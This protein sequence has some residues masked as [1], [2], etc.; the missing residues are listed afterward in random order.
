M[1]KCRELLATA[2]EN[3]NVLSVEQVKEALSGLTEEQYEAVYAFFAA[4]QVR[5]RGILSA[6]TGQLGA[7]ESASGSIGKSSDSAEKAQG[8]KEEMPEAP[9]ETSAPGDS[10]EQ[11][12]HQT[13]GTEKKT[14][15][16]GKKG[17]GSYTTA[18]GKQKVTK[19]TPI[20]SKY[21]ALYERE[22]S[23]LPER[24]RQEEDALFASFCQGET[25][26]RDAFIES[27]LR[28][29][30]ELAAL[31]ADMGLRE[32]DLIQEGNLGFLLCLDQL[33]KEPEADWRT[34]LSTAVMNAMEEA[35]YAHSSHQNL[36]QKS[37]AESEMVK[38]AVDAFSK[39]H[40]FRP[41]LAELAEMM[42]MPEEELQQIIQLSVDAISLR[43]DPRHMEDAE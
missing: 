43:E 23:R 8:S 32:E 34:A 1:A 2:Q 29:V 27:Q 39:K 28:M 17:A 33:K 41:N 11:T 25:A 14:A 26:A 18:P 3:G 5:V 37:I 35:V 24:T 40:G 4:H 38:G 7:K 12:L 13:T 6:R 21:L 19:V 10:K 20:A 16:K 15:P 30:R 9:E 42:D 36:L 31:F 22:L